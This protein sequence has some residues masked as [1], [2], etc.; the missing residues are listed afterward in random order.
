MVEADGGEVRADG[1]TLGEIVVRGNVVMSGY[2][3]DPEATE[4][5]MGDGWFPPAT[6]PWCTRTATSRSATGSRT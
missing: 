4:R 5:A 3:H 1:Q 6:R 2:Y